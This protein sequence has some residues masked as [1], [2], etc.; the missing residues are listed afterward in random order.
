MPNLPIKISNNTILAAGIILVGLIAVADLVMV[1][2]YGSTTQQAITILYSAI[3]RSNNDSFK[4]E[5]NGHLAYLQQSILGVSQSCN[6]SSRDNLQEINTLKDERSIYN[7]SIINLTLYIKTLN[8]TGTN[9]TIIYNN[10]VQVPVLI[11]TTDNRTC[12]EKLL[13]LH[14]LGP[15]FDLVYCCESRQYGFSDECCACYR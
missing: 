14:G 5:V 6:I 8:C 12:R 9:T 2:S 10:T 13:N 1:L 11:N 15:Y 7:Q 3:S 4:Q